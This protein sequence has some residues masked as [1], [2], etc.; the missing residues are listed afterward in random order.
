M[1]IRIRA[2]HGITVALCAVET[3]PKPGDIYLDDAAHHALSTKF[4]LDW[5]EEG[6]LAESMADPELVFVM[7]SQK[8]RDAKQEL[9]RWLALAEAKS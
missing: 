3:D 2:I 4:G 8:V 9:E 7:E 1:A 6:F 5:N